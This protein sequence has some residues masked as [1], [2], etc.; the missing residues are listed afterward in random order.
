MCC[1]RVGYVGGGDGGSEHAGLKRDLY[2]IEP[3]H[4]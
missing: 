4:G 3:D 1:H 2:Q